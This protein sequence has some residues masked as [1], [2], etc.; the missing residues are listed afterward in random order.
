MLS[1]FSASDLDLR[2]CVMLGYSERIELLERILSKCVKHGECW[3]W[4]GPTSGS[5]RGGGYGRTH[6]EG[7]TV[8]VHRTVYILCY[9][10]IP[11]KKQIDHKCCNRLCCNP[12]HLQR[13]T[14]KSNQKLRDDRARSQT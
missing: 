8:S 14:H 6:H 13:V 10:P 3:L 9:G 1:H 11:P 2:S 4:T 5:G 7:K 12:H